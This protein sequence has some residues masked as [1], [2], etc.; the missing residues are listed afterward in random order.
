MIN[1]GSKLWILGI[2]SEGPG[3]LI[4]TKSGGS[5]ELLGA[6]INVFTGGASIPATR[7]IISNQ[8]SNVSASFATMGP[9]SQYFQTIVSETQNGTS[10]T[11]QYTQLPPRPTVQGLP[12]Y[13]NNKNQVFLPLYVG[14]VS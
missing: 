12:S 1:N 11:I 9:T 14:R 3:V 6:E 2:K 7:P 13:D 8:D 4:L 10:G 5:T